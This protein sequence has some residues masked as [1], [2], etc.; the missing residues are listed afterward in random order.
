[1]TS[2]GTNTSSSEPAATRQP[3]PVTIVTGF[4]GAG[5]TTLLNRI[6]NG[7]HGLQD[8]LHQRTFWMP[9]LGKRVISLGGELKCSTLPPRSIGPI[10]HEQ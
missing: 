8:T 2:S 9:R 6:L 7:K 3:I 5:K 4:L 10:W 1:M